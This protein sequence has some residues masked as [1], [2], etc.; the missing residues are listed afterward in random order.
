MSNIRNSKKLNECKTNVHDVFYTP[1][2]LA[3]RMI[4]LTNLKQND[5]VL[6]AFAG[7]MVFFDCFPSFVKKGW[8]EITEGKDFFDYVEMVDWVVSN[9]PYS[10][11]DKIFKKLVLMCNKGF[12]LLLS[13]HNLTPK[14]IDEIQKAGF[15]LRLI[16][17]VRIKGWFGY[18]IVCFWE[19]GFKNVVSCDREIKKIAFLGVSV[20]G[21]HKKPNPVPIRLRSHFSILP[22]TWKKSSHLLPSC[23]HHPH[24]DFP[25]KTKTHQKRRKSNGPTPRTAKAHPQPFNRAED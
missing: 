7:K 23:L 24:F 5:M 19:K 3:E 18:N 9:P 8:C 25:W 14:R 1:K 12:T 13:M 6:D 11:L 15:G 17:F 10:L 21:I 4:C 16:H 22:P 20:V 2:G